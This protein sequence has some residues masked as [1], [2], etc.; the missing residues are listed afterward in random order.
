M[1][2]EQ[3]IRELKRQIADRDATIE[4]LQSHLART[5]AQMDELFKVNPVPLFVVDAKM[6]IQNANERALGALG[7]SADSLTGQPFLQVIDPAWHARATDHL[8]EVHTGKR[9][10]TEIGLATCEGKTLFARLE[11]MALD[12]NDRALTLVAVLVLAQ[13]PANLQLV[14]DTFDRRLDRV[15]TLSTRYDRD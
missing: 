6:Q 11:S 10:S 8:A 14:G 9:R 5:R 3:T 1:E 15:R 2:P 7:F 13:D 12:D 4:H